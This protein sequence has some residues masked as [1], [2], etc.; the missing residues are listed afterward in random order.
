[1][2]LNAAVPKP[3]VG[4]VLTTGLVAEQT[5][6]V[7]AALRGR[8]VAELLKIQVGELVAMLI[9]LAATLQ[10]GSHL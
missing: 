2:P 7:T 6:E 8:V 5:P 10:S 4:A 9:R 3:M 1:M